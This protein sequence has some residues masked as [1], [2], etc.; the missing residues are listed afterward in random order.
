MFTIGEQ[1]SYV[2]ATLREC[3]TITSASIPLFWTLH[4]TMRE[5]YQP[6]ELDNLYDLFQIIKICFSISIRNILGHWSYIKKY[7]GIIHN[8]KMKIVVSVQP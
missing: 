2:G 7:Q 8:Y 1:C 4:T 6:Y 3:S 5:H